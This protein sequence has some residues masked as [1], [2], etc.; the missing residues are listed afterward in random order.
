MGAKGEGEGG[1]GERTYKIY[2][3]VTIRG[4][5]I[6]Y[7]AGMATWL[8]VTKAKPSTTGACCLVTRPNAC[9]FL[10]DHV[11][12]TRLS[13]TQTRHGPVCGSKSRAAER[14]LG[15]VEKEKRGKGKGVVWGMG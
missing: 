13:I 12:N 15:M 4:G 1:K 6:I 3:Q 8:Q 7:R 10:G 14:S 11:E 2:V 5:D 9:M